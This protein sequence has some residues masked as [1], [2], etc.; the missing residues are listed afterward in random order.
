[1]CVCERERER[2]RKRERAVVQVKGQQVYRLV[3][4]GGEGRLRFGY[5]ST[6]K[7]VQGVRLFRVDP[8]RFAYAQ[9]FIRG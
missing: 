5:F 8:I 4:G 3:G 9:T 2:E 6:L 7:L 1:M